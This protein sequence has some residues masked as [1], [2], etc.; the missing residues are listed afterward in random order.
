MNQPEILS[1][2]QSIFN[3]A[4]DCF[5]APAL[6]F[7]SRF[8]QRTIDR[9][10]LNPGDRVLDVCC[11]TGASAIPAALAVGPTG[12]ILG[13][14]L[15]DKL[16]E[17]AKNKAQ[18]QRLENIEFQCRDFETLEFSDHS[19]DAVVCVFGIFFVPDMETAVQKLW[20]IVRPGGQLAITSWGEQIFEPAS[21]FLR[22]LL[23]AECPELSQHP[24]PW[25]RIVT[26]TSFRTLLETAEVSGIEIFSEAS[27]HELTSPKDWWTMV[28]GGGL[29]G[30]IE[31]LD[32]SVREQIRQANLQFLQTHHIRALAV[33]VLYAIARKPLAYR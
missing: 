2:T 28:L 13:V 5:D 10:A 8:G 25:E 31:Q 23:A 15:A 32:P 33:D 4:A 30:T 3:T 19:F 1:K 12:Q 17:L 26:P 11:G 6:S 7:W 18:Q 29:R 24:L 16:L 9:L 21:Q 14:D 27:T 22:S 20:R